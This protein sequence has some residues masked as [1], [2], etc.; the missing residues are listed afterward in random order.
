MFDLTHLR[1]YTPITLSEAA[2]RAITGGDGK[3]I[4]ER[5]GHLPEA[6]IQVPQI[7]FGVTDLNAR[8]L[9][10]FPPD[11]TSGST[12][13]RAGADLFTVRH[14]VVHSRYGLVTSGE[15]FFTDFLYHAPMYRLPGC[16]PTADGGFLFPGNAPQIGLD[17]AFHL[18][19]GNSD[20]YYHWMVDVLGRFDWDLYGRHVGGSGS[21]LLIPT[22]NAPWKRQSFELLRDGR[23]SVI[24]CSDD[25]IIYSEQMA[26]VLDLSGCG[27]FPHPGSLRPFTRIRERLGLG[28]GVPGRRLYIS[29]QDSTQRRLVNE[30]QVIEEV[31]QA[32][33]EAVTLT[34]MTVA[35]QARLFDEASHI[36]APHGAGLTNILFCRPGTI[37]LELHMDS[38]TQWAFS[39]VGRGAAYKLRLP[40][41][42]RG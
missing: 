27:F 18:L 33:F 10:Q 19:A 28:S 41:R 5:D 23:Q 34:G 2:D 30:E 29:R 40:D 11:T 22:L 9:R 37:L 16:G 35:E 24:Q 20:N 21:T 36:I 26:V 31:V 13:W 17:S 25:S 42:R 32:G 39:A 12:R 38:Y 1:R 8:P 15:Y 3:P 7:A 4:V 14:A 6:H